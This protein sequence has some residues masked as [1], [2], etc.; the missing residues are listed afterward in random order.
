MVFRLPILFSALV[1][2]VSAQ[3]Q[4]IVD[5]SQKT[6]DC[7]A[8]AGYAKRLPVRVTQLNDVLYS[9]NVAATVRNDWS[10]DF[11][12]LAMMAG[13]IGFV[14]QENAFDCSEAVLAAVDSAEHEM[15][16]LMQ[17]FARVSRPRL[18]PDGSVDSVAL[19]TTLQQWRAL[20]A[21]SRYHNVAQKVRGLDSIEGP[22]EA[23]VAD[24]L[25]ALRTSSQKLLD[26]AA[27]TQL[28][29]EWTGDVHLVSGANNVIKIRV[30]ETFNGVPTGEPK[31]LSCEIKSSVLS[32]SAGSLFSSIPQRRYSI[33]DVPGVGQDGR[34]LNSTYRAVAVENASQSSL[35]TVAL[36]NYVIPGMSRDGWSMHASSGPVVSWDQRHLPTSLG[37]F[38]GVSLSIG[39]RFFFT[40]GVQRGE[41]AD[42]PMG[43]TEGSAV[44]P[45]A[46]DSLPDPIRR[47]TSRPA[48]SVTY[49]TKTFEPLGRREALVNGFVAQNPNR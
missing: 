16:L 21:G 43:Y 19:R 39:Q 42:F 9:Y 13:E 47:W 6:I 41:I 34:T 23:A 37:Y 12:R 14:A 32:L 24:R 8:E 2:L 5:W 27:S 3:E 17:D 1:C 36:L 48:W 10:D 20:E 44:P 26:F 35:A 22:C 28:P 49:R 18:F 30:S 40:A 7:P 38:A 15:K 4:I 29:H 46:G 45:V 33:V 25:E 11:S 31:V